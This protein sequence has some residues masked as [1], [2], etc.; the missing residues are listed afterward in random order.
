MFL[1]SFLLLLVAISVA[2]PQA[3]RYK[4]SRARIRNFH[5]LL[6]FFLACLRKV[7]DVFTCVIR[8]YCVSLSFRVA[9]FFFSD[10]STT[11]YLQ[12]L[13]RLRDDLVGTFFCKLVWLVRN[14][15]FF[16]MV[17]ATSFFTSWYSAI[18][19]L[20]IRLLFVWKSSQWLRYFCSNFFG[21]PSEIV[22]GKS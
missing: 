15:N 11:P 10:D 12:H 7:I 19:P 8:Y 17:I 1:S 20:G 21:A 14:I 4:W 9:Y 22:L 5:F 18:V 3:C 2:Y 13:E 6:R 16:L